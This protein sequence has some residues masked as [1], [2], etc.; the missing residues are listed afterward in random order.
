MS[1][2]IFT[3]G[4]TLF[5]CRQEIPALE[6]QSQGF[7]RGTITGIASDDET[8]INERFRYTQYQKPVIGETFA[9]YLEEDNGSF[10]VVLFRLDLAAGGYAY[11]SFTLDDEK[12]TTPNSPEM[13]I[14]YYKDAEYLLR[15]YMTSNDPNTLAIED[16]FFDPASGKTTGTFRME[17]PQ[18]SS[19]N[20]ALVEGSFDLILQRYRE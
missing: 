14:A 3:T 11:A 4:I 9:G 19:E 20:E 15:F 8:V 18:N 1:L 7:I 10:R 2:L 6:Y 17:G 12:D 5:G 13:E 16:F